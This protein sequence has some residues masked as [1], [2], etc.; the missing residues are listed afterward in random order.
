MVIHGFNFVV[1]NP[2]AFGWNR[3][4]TVLAAI[5]IGFVVCFFVKITTAPREPFGQ[6]WEA[7]GLP[8]LIVVAIVILAA[9]AMSHDTGPGDGMN[10]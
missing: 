9:L 3:G 2:A 1:D 6:W 4:M 7:T 5:A 8:L 10:Y